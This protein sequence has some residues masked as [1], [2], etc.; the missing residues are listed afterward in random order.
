MSN[1]NSELHYAISN[2]DL[3]KCEYLIKNGADLNYIYTI[4]T[5]LIAAARCGFIDICK[6]LI[7]NGADVN[8]LTDFGSSALGAAIMNNKYDVC[9][10]LIDNGADVNIN[11][12]RFGCSLLHLVAKLGYTDICKLL[13]DSGANVNAL[14]RSNNLPIHFSSRYIDITKLFIDYGSN[15]DIVDM[16]GETPFCSAK[17]QYCFK[18]ADLIDSEISKLLI[19]NRR[20]NIIF[21]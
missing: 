8:F 13:L 17:K 14:N 1:L 7:D 15:L 18:V 4:S 2:R 6:L 19:F 5:P 10:F 16:Y 20:K 3:S 9:K 21:F 12:L 11:W